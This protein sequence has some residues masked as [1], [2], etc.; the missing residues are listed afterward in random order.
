MRRRAKV[1]Q[2]NSRQP[3]GQI[4]I[5]DHIVCNSSASGHNMVS[6]ALDR[7]VRRA[8]ALKRM[9][10]RKPDAAATLCAV[11]AAIEDIQA[12]ALEDS[13]SLLPE[14]L[15]KGLMHLLTSG[16]AAQAAFAAT[17]LW[18]TIPAGSEPLINDSRLQQVR[19]GNH[20]EQCSR[21]IEWVVAMSL[22]GRGSGV[23]HRAW[24]IRSSRFR[25]SHTAPAARHLAGADRSPGGR[26]AAPPRPC[27]LR[28]PPAA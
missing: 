25:A 5:P 19:G 20:L 3:H 14:P 16:T 21:S 10:Q 11:N 24:L 28:P 12:A 23:T 9:L 13:S 26:R 15:V 2:H 4:T 17:T 6:S 8:L 1:L 22:R 7:A 18:W 27:R